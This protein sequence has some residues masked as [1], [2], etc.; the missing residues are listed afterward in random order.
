[1]PGFDCDND[2]EFLN[3]YLLRYFAKLPVQFTRSRPYNKNHNAHV[4][5][6]NWSHIRS[7]LAMI[8]WKTQGSSI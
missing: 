6:K 5:Q 7:Y 4:E 1:M 3:H 8:A 2:S